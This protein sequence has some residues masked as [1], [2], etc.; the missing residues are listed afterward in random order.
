MN[1]KGASAYMTA[2][3]DLLDRISLAQLAA[4]QTAA[5]MVAETARN[6]HL[7]YLFG[8]GHSHILCEEGHYRAGGLAPVCPILFSGLM[9]HESA[10][11]STQLE[12][13]SGLASEILKRYPL[14]KNDLMFIFSNSGV[15][16]VPVEAALTAK[17]IGMKTIAIMSLA[18]AM[19][20]DTGKRTKLYEVADLVIDNHGQ[21]GDA[22]IDIT[23]SGLRGG[24]VSSI[25]GLYILN[26]IFVEAA[27][28]IAEFGIEPIPIYISSNLPGH[29]KHNTNLVK[30]YRYRNRHL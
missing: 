29:E 13:T 7:I 3:R 10:L 22:I 24:P 12:R 5:N 9:L 14:T 21:P 19:S 17:A 27:I 4:I 2:V 1:V 25:A 26:A 23:D 8:T 15:N 16:A 28:R 18:Y 11:I 6:D 20:I 30:R